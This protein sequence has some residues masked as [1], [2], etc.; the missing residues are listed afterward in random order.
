MKAMKKKTKKTGRRL[1]GNERLRRQRD[2]WDDTAAAAAI[3]GFTCLEKTARTAVANIRAKSS[4]TGKDKRKE[5]R[6]VLSN[7]LDVVDNN[8]RGIALTAGGGT[9]G[10]GTGSPSIG[11]LVD[12][13]KS[14]FEAS[15]VA[16]PKP[17]S[18]AHNRLLAARLSKF[19][20]PP[21]PSPPPQTIS[22]ECSDASH[23]LAAARW[24]NAGN[25]RTRRAF[26]NDEVQT[27]TRQPRT[28]DPLTPCKAPWEM[29]KRK[30]RTSEQQKEC[31]SPSVTT[32]LFLRGD[33]VVRPRR[34]IGN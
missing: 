13:T 12:R 19:N 34:P 23:Q 3:V 20:R 5:H 24:V 10:P 29:H 26:L 25:I 14:L 4:R 27:P 9:M 2:K 18:N 31:V 15:L 21:P 7:E 6:R 33:R 22:V 28:P 30:H 17:K 8:L 11:E 16:K 1:P 32:E